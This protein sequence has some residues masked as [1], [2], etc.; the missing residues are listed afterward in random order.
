MA[1]SNTLFWLIKEQLGVTLLAYN[2]YLIISL[3]K[4]ILKVIKLDA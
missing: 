2:R 4:Y 1:L 3:N